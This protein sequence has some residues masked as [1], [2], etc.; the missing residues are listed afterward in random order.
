MDKSAAAKELKAKNKTV[1]LIEHN[2]DFIEAVADN[3]LFLD[4]C[5]FGSAS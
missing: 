3:I 4:S 5:D 1:L 2:T